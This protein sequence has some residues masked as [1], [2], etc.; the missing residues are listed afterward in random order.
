MSIENRLEDLG[1]KLEEVKTPKFSYT[2]VTQVGN[3]VYTS[4]QD[5][6]VNGELIL[7]GKLG[8]ELTIEEGKQ[9]ARQCAINCLS[10]LKWHLGSLDKIKKVVKVL[11]FVQSHDEFKD[12]PYVMNGASD[13]FLE[14]FG[15]KGK[16]ARSA[17]GANELPFNTPVEVEIIVEIED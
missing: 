16:H 3:L 6:R 5:C 13:L 9:A 4:G 12:Q 7:E 15:E 2:P 14:V 11:G 10:V 1:I 8:R 17:I